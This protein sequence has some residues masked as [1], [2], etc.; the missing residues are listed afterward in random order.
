[1][2][3]SRIT[4]LA[5]STMLFWNDTEVT[6]YDSNFLRNEAVFGG[7]LWAEYNSSVKCVNVTFTENEALQGGAVMLD[8]GSRLMIFNGT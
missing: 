6:I 8:S 5:F 4:R 2:W 7:A 1:M 3:T